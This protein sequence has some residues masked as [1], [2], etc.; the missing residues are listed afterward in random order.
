M[1]R[2]RRRDRQKGTAEDP[3][4]LE[5]GDPRVVPDWSKKCSV[6]GASPILPLTGLC[7]P[8]TFGESE[9]IDGNW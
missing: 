8:C 1:S 6:C 9:T 4:V 5:D 7:G 3:I 2:R